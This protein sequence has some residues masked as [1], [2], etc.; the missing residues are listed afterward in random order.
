MRND[1]P[2]LLDT[3]LLLAPADRRF[4][5]PELVR[6]G[7]RLGVPPGHVKRAVWKLSQQFR[8]FQ[9]RARRDAPLGRR[10]NGWAMPGTSTRTP[11]GPIYEYRLTPVG[12]MERAALTSDMRD[13]AA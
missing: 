7:G 8:W 3:V 11:C 1:N 12:I 13:L 6:S 10:P 5:L 2:W 4:T 9:R